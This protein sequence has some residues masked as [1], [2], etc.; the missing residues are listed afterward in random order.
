MAGFIKLH[1]SILK[2]EW[3]TDIPVRILFEH[4]LLRA[5]HENN[6]WCGKIIQRGSFITSLAKLAQETGLTIKQ[7]RT[8]LDKLKM[9]HELACEG[10][11]RYS[12]ITINNWDLYQS[13]DTQEDIQK[14][15]EGHAEGKQRAANKN[16]KNEKNI[17]RDTR[18]RD[19]RYIENT[20]LENDPYLS[21]NVQKFVKTWHSEVN[22]PCRLSPDE[23]L[24]LW[25]IINDLIMQDLTIDEICSNICEN[26]KKINSR[27]DFGINWLLKDDNFYSILNGE[28]QQKKELPKDFADTGGP[29]ESWEAQLEEYFRQ[30]GHDD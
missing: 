24:K 20:D 21:E 27:N 2:W 17:E 3:Y 23:R 1:R 8:A 6:K 18:A 11:S 26:F 19:K 30:R 28:W 13:K 14:A 16:D 22:K 29:N 25:N 5:N 15:N 9:T 7:V 12:I 4:C 10:H